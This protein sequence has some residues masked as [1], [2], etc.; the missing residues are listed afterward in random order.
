[1]KL[2]FK[3]DARETGLAGVGRPNPDTFIKA[4][5]KRIGTI[6]APTFITKDNLWSVSLMVKREPTPRDPCDFQWISF[7]ARF[8][9]EADAR[10]WIKK[11]WDALCAKYDFRQWED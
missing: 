9:E 10:E 7:K 4:D 8:A 5:K 2:S 11:Y 1:M 6:V 3:K